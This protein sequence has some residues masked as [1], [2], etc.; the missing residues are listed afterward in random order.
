MLE[1]IRISGFLSK[2]LFPS[3]ATERELPLPRFQGPRC[4]TACILREAL[5][6]GDV[7]L[8]DR[9]QGEPLPLEHGGPIRLIVPQLYGFKSV[10]HVCAIRPRADYRRSFAERRTLA[11]P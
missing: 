8:V 2:T 1:R 4:Y 6:Q 11:H 5:L 3:R 7:L 10:K 9:L